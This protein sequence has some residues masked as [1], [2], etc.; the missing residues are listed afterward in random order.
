LTTLAAQL[1]IDCE[2]ELEKAGDDP[3]VGIGML[4]HGLGLDVISVLNPTT[5]LDDLI[6]STRALTW[7]R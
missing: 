6:A 5:N 1:G 4:A 3:L 7:P 2:H